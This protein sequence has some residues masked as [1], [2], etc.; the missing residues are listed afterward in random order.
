MKYTFWFKLAAGFQFL[1][2][3]GHALSFLSEPV[4]ANDT[5]K[6]LFEL[7]NTYKMD[8]GA[9]YFRTMTDLVTSF[10][11]CFTLLYLFAALLN[12]YLLRSKADSQ[13]LRGVIIINTG[14]FGICFA[15]MFVFTFL[16]PIVLTGLVAISLLLS[17]MTLPK[18]TAGAA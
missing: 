16:P 6:T 12:W 13:I 17:L 5:E 10:S 14:I 4:A 9:G 1:T 15:V 11:A 3:L 8:L 2:A 18:N 7:M